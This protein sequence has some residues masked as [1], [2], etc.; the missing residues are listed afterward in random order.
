MVFKGI[1]FI[2]MISI[3]FIALAQTDQTDLKFEK[4]I[5]EFIE[6]IEKNIEDMENEL[7]G[8]TNIALLVGNT[9]SGKSTIFNILCGAEF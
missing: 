6:K 2:F 7:N 1:F 4:Q 5:L 9:G 3:S 8:N